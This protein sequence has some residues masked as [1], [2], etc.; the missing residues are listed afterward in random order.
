MPRFYIYAFIFILTFIINT[1]GRVHAFKS[2]YKK[3]EMP[4]IIQR[5]GY[6]MMFIPTIVIIL[7]TI[8]SLFSDDLEFLIVCSIMTVVFLIIT[9]FTRRKFRR[10]YRETEEHFIMNG[11]YLAFQVEYDDIVD[12]IPLPKQIGVL[13]GTR[14]D[15]PYLCLHYKFADLEILLRKLAEM[16]FA[17]KF[18][19][20]DEN[21]MDDPYREQELIDHLQ[22][23][24]YGHIIEEVKQDVS[25]SE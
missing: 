16:T 11:Q 1:I 2:A 15:G 8:F 13:D 17:G 14:E 20:T 3:I 22:K 7:L 24:G 5:V 18:P 12:W 10:L 4:S 6:N 25:L 21:K 23:H 9:Y 19:Q